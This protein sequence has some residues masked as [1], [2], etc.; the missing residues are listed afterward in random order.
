MAISSTALV[1]L[2]ETKR[3]LQL[4]N[5]VDYDKFLV[6]L[7]DIA[8][9]HIEQF[10]QR[11]FVTT[12]HRVWLDG[13][14]NGVLMLPDFPVT[15]ISRI[16]WETSTAMSVTAS[17]AS[18]IR[19]TVEVKDDSMIMKRWNSS[20]TKTT[21]TIAYSSN[22]TSTALATSISALSGWSA[23]ADKT[24]LAE[25]L[26]PIGG[27]DAK[28]STAKVYSINDTQHEYKCEEQTG[29]LTMFMSESEQQWSPNSEF[30]VLFPKGTGN[31]FVD[32]DA[33]FAQASIPSALKQ[34]CFDIISIGFH[35]GRHDP[36]TASESLDAYSYSTRNAMEL[37]D[38][39]YSKMLPY[40]RSSP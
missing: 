22:A 40:R 29:R 9:S 11:T 31:V 35:A 23:T 8:T 1:E 25:D 19:A 2:A 32:Y 24:V 39:Q 33:G 18:D 34:V 14:G 15:S 6:D 7:I 17:T 4:G 30:G 27:Q 21:D 12:N 28:E 10:C 20:G 16:G 36:T 37:R 13:S 26:L 38:D 3:Y 5:T